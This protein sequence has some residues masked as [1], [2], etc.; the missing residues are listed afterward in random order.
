MSLVTTWSNICINFNCW[1]VN[2]KDWREI[3]KSK[4][5]HIFKTINIMTNLFLCSM[6]VFNAIVWCI[7]KKFKRYLL[8]K[9]TKFVIRWRHN[10]TTPLLTLWALKRMN[11]KIVQQFTTQAPNNLK[12]LSLMHLG[13]QHSCYKMKH[14]WVKML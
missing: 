13:N 7:T 4:I 2:A 12:N 10:A 11:N 1:N 9:T 8:W 5:T 14:N 6:Y 3:H